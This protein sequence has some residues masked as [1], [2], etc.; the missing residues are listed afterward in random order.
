MSLFKFKN[1]LGNVLDPLVKEKSSRSRA[2]LYET[3]SFFRS[4]HGAY[5]YPPMSTWH[6]VSMFLRQT[7]FWTAQTLKKAT[8]LWEQAGHE[9]N[10]AS[11]FP[12]FQRLSWPAW[13]KGG[14]IGKTKETELFL[15]AA[16]KQEIKL[17]TFITRTA[18]PNT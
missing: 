10:Y 17:A 4:L 13:W 12:R 9:N 6:Y 2:F 7:W 15:S 11:Q 8:G 18:T 1:K 5:N 16:F 3:T 14:L